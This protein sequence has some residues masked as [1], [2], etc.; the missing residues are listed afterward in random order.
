MFDF[1]KYKYVSIVVSTILIII[2]F[3][4]TFGKYGGFATSLDF[5]GGLRTVVEFDKSVE[6]KTLEEYFSSKGLEAVLVHMDKEKNHYQIDIGLGSADRIKE[7]YLQKKGTSTPEAKQ[8]SAIDALIG[9]L[10]EDF[11]LDKKAILSANQ[12]GSVVGAE[13][14]TTGIT[15]LGLTLLIILGYLSFRFQ[16]KFALGASLALIHDLIITIAFIGFFQIKPSVPIIAA[17]LTLLGYS[18][19][20]TIVVFDRIREN[21]GNMKDVFSNVINISINQT[22]SRTINTSFATLISVVAIIIGGAVELYDFAYVLTFGIILG[23]FSSIFIAAPLIDI[24]DSVYKR[25]KK[26]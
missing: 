5:D 6:R 1:I 23:T 22:L 2:G 11:K 10:T 9:L 12:V 15:L 13:L 24:Y 14:T 17:L 7:L 25:F 19:N 3:G 16:F 18:I 4:V 21:A 26:S 20:D 8:I